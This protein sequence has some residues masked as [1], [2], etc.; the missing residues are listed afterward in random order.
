VGTV[1]FAEKVF[2][3]EIAEINTYAIGKTGGWC[4]IAIV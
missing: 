2:N 4:K 3:L 1:P